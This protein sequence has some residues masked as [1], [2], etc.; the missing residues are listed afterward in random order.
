M[1]DTQSNSGNLS[2]FFA[3]VDPQTET[4]ANPAP[5]NFP[6]PPA[7]GQV[8]VEKTEPVSAPVAPAPDL[9]SPLVPPPTTIPEENLDFSDKKMAAKKKLLIFAA[10]LFLVGILVLLLGTIIPKLVGKKESEVTLTYWGLW[11]P[12]SVMNGIITEYQKTHPKVK[13]NY[14]QNLGESA[15]NYRERL[16]AAL[17]RNE[18]DIFR[19][20]NTWVPM[21]KEF[22]S[23]IPSNVMDAATFEKTYY[24]VSRTDLKFANGY[25]GLPLMMDGLALYYNEDIFAT[26]GKLPPRTW[27]EF[28]QLA[29]ELT[30]RDSSGKIQTAGAALGTTNNVDHWSEILGL[31]LLQN[32]A[33][34]ANPTDNYAADAISFYT[35]FVSDH[36]VWDSS[37]P[38]STYSFA[39]GRLA[40]YFGPSW[41]VFDIKTLN[42]GL[43]FKIIP[44]PQL[45][46]VDLAWASYWV[47][48]VSNK[49]VRTKEAWE[50]LRFLA[51]KETMQKLYQSQSQLR[52]FGEPYSRTDMADLLRNELYVGPYIQ[53]AVKARSWYL[54]SRTHD[55]GINDEI[56]KYY[57]NAVNSIAGGENIQSSLATAAMGINQ[58]L[59]KYGVK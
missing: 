38:P 40:M 43:K 44:V 12:A 17:D 53:Q 26:A 32:N 37:L 25:V 57:E 4:A 10:A 41:R 16:R 33:N 34:L 42:P 29:V 9:S 52:L 2:D 23:P 13:I 54:C 22:L 20:H 1:T 15:K 56:I 47:E 59:S 48:G 18:V 6:N 24:P 27:E 7:V 8:V 11:E 35:K 45:S 3:K 49:S 21:F 36:R 30:V 31:M 50:F 28:R 46:G 5:P 14:V 19:F 55:N 58:V 51:E 39:S